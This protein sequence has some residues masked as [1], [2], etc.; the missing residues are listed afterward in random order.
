[1][2]STRTYC[3]VSVHVFWTKIAPLLMFSGGFTTS[4]AFTLL[5]T[6]ELKL[7]HFVYYGECE[8]E[9]ADTLIFSQTG[10]F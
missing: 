4:G 5:G 3:S 1:M 2:Y 7:L 10:G 9:K 6:H 8:R